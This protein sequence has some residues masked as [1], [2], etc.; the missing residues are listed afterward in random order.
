MK[1]RYLK[2]GRISEEKFR[3]FLRVFSLDL[4]ATKIAELTKLNRN[5]VNRFIKLIRIRMAEHCEELSPLKGEVEADES[6]FGPKRT[7]GKRG[8]GAGSKTIVFGLLKRKGKVYT[9]IV[10]DC[11]KT[12]STKGYTWKSI[13]RIDYTYG[14]LARI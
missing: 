1:N 9:E 6:Y 8:R 10:P 14:W 13:C 4:E 7:K 2:N 3:S 11:L 5:S 12:H